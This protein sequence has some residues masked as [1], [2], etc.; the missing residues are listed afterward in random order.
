MMPKTYPFSIDLRIAR[1]GA[2][3]DLTLITNASPRVVKLAVKTVAREGRN[4]TLTGVLSFA[5][6]SRQIYLIPALSYR[7]G[8]TR[9]IQPLQWPMAFAVFPSSDTQS[10]SEGNIKL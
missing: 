9:Y 1:P 4:I 7:F 10:F 8:A 2:P 3:T 6:R 5:E